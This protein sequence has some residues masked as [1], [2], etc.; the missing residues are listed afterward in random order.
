MTRRGPLPLLRHYWGRQIPSFFIF[1]CKVER[2]IPRRVAAPF[3][4]A[5]TQPDSSRAGDAPARPR[6]AMSMGP[7]QKLQKGFGVGLW[8]DRSRGAGGPEVAA[9]GRAR[10]LHDPAGRRAY[11]LPASVAAGGAGGG[12]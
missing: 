8:A 4:P 11:F 1:S 5:S 9:P 3:G 7:E 6:P 2:F 12:R 10:L